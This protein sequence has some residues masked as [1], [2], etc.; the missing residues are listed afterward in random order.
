MFFVQFLLFSFLDTCIVLL[1]AVVHS[2]PSLVLDL[3]LVTIVDKL[4]FK[5]FQFGTLEELALFTASTGH[6]VIQPGSCSDPALDHVNL[7]FI[8]MVRTEVRI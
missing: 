3:S 1:H 2:V 7:I 8:S 5:V 6:T 4:L